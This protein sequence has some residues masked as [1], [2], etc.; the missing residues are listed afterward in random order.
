M[1]DTSRNKAAAPNPEKTAKN[2]AKDHGDRP[3]GKDDRSRTPNRT[4][5]STPPHPREKADEDSSAVVSM[6]VREHHLRDQVQQTRHEYDSLVENIRHRVHL[7]REHIE[8][9][10]QSLRTAEASYDESRP[11]GADGKSS[12]RPRSRAGDHSDLAF[13]WIESDD[14]RQGLN[15]LLRLVEKHHQE[16]DLRQRTLESDLNDAAAREES[17]ST[18][19]KTSQRDLERVTAARDRVENELTTKQSE[20]DELGQERA[21]C[22]EQLAATIGQRDDARQQL[23]HLQQEHETT[24]QRLYAELTLREA[25]ERKVVGLETSTTQL[26]EENQTI[27]ET[28]ERVDR[29]LTEKTTQLQADVEREQAHRA[30]LQTETNDLRE[31]LAGSQ[32]ELSAERA[33]LEATREDVM[34]LLAAHKEIKA[35]HRSLAQDADRTERALSAS[36][37]DLRERLSQMTAQH[38]G[39]RK[40][41]ETLQRQR[42]REQTQHRSAREDWQATLRKVRQEAKLT[43]EK[44]QLQQRQVTSVLQALREQ[45]GELSDRCQKLEQNNDELRADRT[46]LKLCMAAAETP[47]VSR[48]IV[49]ADGQQLRI[50]AAQAGPAPHLQLRFSDLHEKRNQESGVRER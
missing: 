28:L 42:E 5:L 31:R 25:A 50:D 41:L 34:R 11:A 12:P 3:P 46:H 29:E 23:G 21:S 27:G 38:D 26:Q 37:D 14:P 43:C 18:K 10:Q 15:Q 47:T 40:E 45:H 9:R 33:R 44:T 22:E 24:L 7:L 2:S 30:K 49:T 6:I 17:L 32:D 48:R 1:K 39:R 19:L 8:T 35:E 13:D 4:P 20:C 16:L 36:L